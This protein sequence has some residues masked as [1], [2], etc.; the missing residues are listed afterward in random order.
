MMPR[1]ASLLFCALALCVTA[2]APGAQGTDTF[3]SLPYL[4]ETDPDAALDRIAELTGRPDADRDPRAVFDLYRMA[5]GLMIEGGQAEQAAQ[6]LARLAD[7]A[8]RDRSTLGIDPLPIYAEAAAL[9]RDTGQARAAR[10]SFLSMYQEQRLTGAA[11][12]DLAR[13][14]RD[15]AALSSALGEAPPALAPAADQEAFEAI[16]LFYATD[17]AISGEPDAPRHY[18]ASGGALEAGLAVVSRAAPPG[19]VDRSKLRAVQTLDRAE[20]LGRLAADPRQGVL[21]YVHGAA[22]PFEQAARRAALLA[23]DLG[24]V[25]LPVLFSWPA[26]GSRL[27]YM[28]DSAATRTAARHLAQLLRDLAARPGLPPPHLVARGMG[29]QVVADALELIAARGEPPAPPFGQLILAVPDMGAERLRDLLPEL[30]PLVQRITLYA[31]EHDSEVGLARRLYG[32]ALRAGWGGEATMADPAMDSVDLSPSA[33]DMLADPAVLADL[34][35]LL[36]RNAAPDRRCGLIPEPGDVVGADVWRFDDGVCANPA[37]IR[38]LARLR[39]DGVRTRKKALQVMETTV[40]DPV[41]RGRLR[42]VVSR[43]T[44]E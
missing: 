35:M 19:P 3:A 36:W 1:L 14:A 4:A 8:A 28:A 6:I 37:L 42:P 25:D 40:S 13:T 15:I 21:V 33:G 11:P 31:S 39:G 9:L 2:S 30:R 10:D 12:E 34:A 41:L 29:A 24:G 22:T 23:S 17:R 16:P 7:F 44:Q 26:S 27:D 32:P 20:W 18:G 43:L 5:A 38:L